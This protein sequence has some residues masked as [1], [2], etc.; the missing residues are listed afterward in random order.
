MTTQFPLSGPLTVGDLLDR[1]FR[2][3]R[4]RFGVFL[5]TAMLFL[6]PWAIISALI[7]G[8]LHAGLFNSDNLEYGDVSGLLFRDVTINAL[9][10]VLKALTA[11]GFVTLA[12]TVQC[13]Q[14]L[15]GG[16]L[17][18]G[19]S[20]RRAL[21]RFWPYLGMTI[22]TWAVLLSVA[23]VVIISVFAGFIALDFLLD[24]LLFDILTGRAINETTNSISS[25]GMNL[26]AL[27]L[28]ALLA[29]LMLAPPIYLLARWLVAP[30]ALIAEGLGPFASLGRSWRLSR[31]YI[32]GV[33]GYVV[34]LLV[35]MTLV[36]YFPATLFQWILLAL[37]PP[38]SSFGLA[39][40]ISGSI[41]SLF[42][43]IG[44]PFYIGAVVL[45][46]YDL[47]VRAESYD[48]ELRIAELEEKAAQDA[49]PD[50]ATARSDVEEVK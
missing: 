39:R 19:Q 49:D 4:A 36:M 14:A 46:Y 33:T 35:I 16:S 2:L 20:I 5:L 7:V 15:H 32:R 41:S 34:L 10:I 40:G 17:T 18:L 38:S 6:V 24:S 23:V 27:F 22:A 11:H 1:A 28:Y 45:L 42:S 25:L 47:R 12:L 31:G 50:G 9:R 26:L 8:E 29:I 30:A 13:V 44:T 3:Y 21:R 43:I 48:L 37:L